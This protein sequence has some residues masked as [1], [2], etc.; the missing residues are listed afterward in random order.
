MSTPQYFRLAVITQDGQGIEKVGEK[1]FE[2]HRFGFY[3]GLS[4][5]QVFINIIF[6]FLANKDLA[7]TEEELIN[8]GFAVVDT[9][10]I[11]EDLIKIVPYLFCDRDYEKREDSFVKKVGL[12]FLNRNLPLM[13]DSLA[14]YLKRK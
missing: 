5:N 10:G 13:T 2:N 8:R 6:S 1:V 11:P 7:A 4:N 14:S 3:N 12:E 9:S